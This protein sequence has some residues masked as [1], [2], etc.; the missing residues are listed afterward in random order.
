MIKC[1]AYSKVSVAG[2]PL[3]FGLLLGTLAAW[4]FFTA[5]MPFSAIKATDVLSLPWS[6]YWLSQFMTSEVGGREVAVSTRTIESIQCRRIQAQIGLY[7]PPP[8]GTCN[9]GAR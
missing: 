1:S 8:L 2:T 3:D 4:Y 9:K 6:P 5:V 7:L